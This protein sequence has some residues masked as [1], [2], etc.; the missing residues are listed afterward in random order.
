MPTQNKS[1]GWTIT[2]QCGDTV[3]EA[4]GEPIQIAIC[5]CA[6]CRAAQG[7]QSATET[8]ALMRRDQVDSHLD[9]LKIVPAED[10]NDNVPRFFCKS[11]NACL[12]G[13]CT[14]V[15]F[16]MVIVPTRHISS[17]VSIG[18]PDYHMHLEE[19]IVKPENDGLPHYNGNPED[20]H[21]ALLIEGCS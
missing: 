12:V 17:E 9:N 14:P 1:E 19:G 7:G 4:H 2:C 13:D 16:D 5:H 3:L 6:D 8:L 15:G 18:A 10:Y 21:M 20:P 11:C